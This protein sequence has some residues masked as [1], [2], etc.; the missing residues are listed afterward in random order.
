[1]RSHILGMTQEANHTR[2]LLEPSSPVVPQSL[3]MSVVPAE[4]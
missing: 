1:M 2:A 3:E 4:L